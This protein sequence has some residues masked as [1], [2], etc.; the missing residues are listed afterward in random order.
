MVGPLG[1]GSRAAPVVAHEL[2]QLNRARLGIICKG[3]EGDS[4]F[5]RV[6]C[7]TGGQIPLLSWFYTSAYISQVFSP[8]VRSRVLRSCIVRSD[9]TCHITG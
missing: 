9:G 7:K 1:A 4:S 3:S 8:W 5:P 6:I 2:R